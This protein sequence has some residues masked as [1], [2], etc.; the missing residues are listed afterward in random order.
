MKT[1]FL[2]SNLCH[3]LCCITQVELVFH[4]TFVN[5]LKSF[6]E[7]CFFFS[8]SANSFFFLHFLINVQ[9]KMN[10]PVVLMVN[11][12]VVIFENTLQDYGFLS[13]LSIKYV[14]TGFIYLNKIILLHT[15]IMDLI[16]I[17]RPHFTLQN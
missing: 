16:S 12:L 8:N 10:Y 7:F 1:V 2:K 15:T 5:M 6:Q 13:F 9:S 3:N 14:S 4:P 17:I 11:H